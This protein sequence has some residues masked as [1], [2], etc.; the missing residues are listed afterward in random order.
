MGSL[1]GRGKA[2]FGRA[3]TE[4]FRQAFPQSEPRLD[5]KAFAIDF[6]HEGNA[7]TLQ[8]D[9][10]YRQLGQHSQAQVLDRLVAALG[11]AFGGLPTLFDEAR[12]SLLPRLASRA[13]LDELRLSGRRAPFRLVGER[14]VALLA[15]DRPTSVAYVDEKQLG[16]WHVEADDTFELAL[17]NLATRSPRPLFAPLA[18][19]LFQSPRQ[20]SWDASTLLLYHQQP[21]PPKLKGQPVVLVANADVLLL[22]GSENLSG[23]EYL[24]DEGEACLEAPRPICA[25][26]LVGPDW[27]PLVLPAEHPL[28]ARWRRLF[29]QSLALAYAEQRAVLERAYDQSGEDVWV[30]SFGL[31]SAPDRP[32]TTVSWTVWPQDVVGVIA[33][34]DLLGV[35]SDDQ[36]APDL[37]DFESVLKA[38]GDR[39]ELVPECWPPRY[40][41]STFPTEQE[42]KQFVARDPG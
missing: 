13:F 37:Y 40:R 35:V 12:Q 20:D 39:L 21:D 36:Q 38:V 24:L 42:R 5:E 25:T 7:G 27:A 10:F 17:R 16:Q 15:L 1:F 41:F 22:T 23:L 14:L 32:E 9:S 11:D 3:A 2:R 18:E 31:I 26:P 33:H 19:G 30:G 28:Y 4:R 29:C 34:T 8:L 6:F